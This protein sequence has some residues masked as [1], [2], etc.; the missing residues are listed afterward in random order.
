M[1][2]KK[3]RGKFDTLLCLPQ[4]KSDIKADVFFLILS[5][6]EKEIVDYQEMIELFLS[7][8][9]IAEGKINRTMLA[10][11]E[12]VNFSKE[13]NQRKKGYIDIQVAITEAD[14][15]RI[16]AKLDNDTIDISAVTQTSVLSSGNMLSLH[17]LQSIASKFTH[18]R[19]LSFNTLNLLISDWQ[20]SN[21]DCV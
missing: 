20:N 2:I 18:N 13:S 7:H 21:N 11:E 8:H 15:I 10:F 6:D 12:I 5:D 19:V 1:S 3:R 17:V 9:N 16:I 4:L 14:D